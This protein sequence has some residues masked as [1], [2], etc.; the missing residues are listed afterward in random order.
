MNIFHTNSID[1]VSYCDSAFDVQSVSEQAVTRKINIINKLSRSR[2]HCARGYAN[3]VANELLTLCTQLNVLA[4]E[5]L[6]VNV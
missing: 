2:T 3:R 1:I 5:I 6:I 4:T